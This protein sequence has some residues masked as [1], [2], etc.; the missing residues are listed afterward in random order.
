MVL[1][2]SQI[3]L[4]ILFLWPFLEVV[5]FQFNFTGASYQIKSIFF[6]T[7]TLY[8]VNN[9]KTILAAIIHFWNGV[10]LGK[11]EKA[12]NK[13]FFKELGLWSIFSRT[14][15]LPKF[16]AIQVATYYA[17]QLFALVEHYSLFYA[18]VHHKIYQSK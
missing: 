2:L 7:G 17:C 6:S 3:T 18:R 8:L 10:K 11:S 14:F 12:L 15:F 4:I 1:W 16:R 13:Y 9:I 5:F